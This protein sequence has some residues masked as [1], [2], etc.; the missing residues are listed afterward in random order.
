[1]GEGLR[2]ERVG[3][4][5]LIRHLTGRVYE[6]MLIL[7]PAFS[8]Q[9]KDIQISHKCYRNKERRLFCRLEIKNLIEQQHHQVK[10][11]RNADDLQQDDRNF[12]IYPSTKVCSFTRDA[13]NEKRAGASKTPARFLY[14]ILDLSGYG[15]DHTSYIASTAS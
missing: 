6:R 2:R 12:H 10:V 14:I 13:V 8:P 5:R 11:D 7:F 9:E 4:G 15:F 3:K 1:M